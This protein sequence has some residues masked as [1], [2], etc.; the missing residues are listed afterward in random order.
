MYPAWPLTAKVPP[1]HPISGAQGIG[2]YVRHLGDEFS[3]T[4]RPIVPGQPSLV[5]ND[6]IELELIHRR[7]ASFRARAKI[8]AWADGQPLIVL[9]L[10]RNYRPDGTVR[11]EIHYSGKPT[12]DTPNYPVK[13]FFAGEEIIS[14]HRTA[15]SGRVFQTTTWR[16]TGLNSN[17]YFVRTK[18]IPAGKLLEGYRAQHMGPVV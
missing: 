6:S 8:G 7:A 5:V 12:G 13:V 17:K 11:T 1:G 10:R 2:D 16:E 15:Q 14:D 3:W 9:E 18:N 4:F